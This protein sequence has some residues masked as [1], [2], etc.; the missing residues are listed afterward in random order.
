MES[1]TAVPFWTK[2]GVPLRRKTGDVDVVCHCCCGVSRVPGFF[3]WY[4]A[5]RSELTD[6]EHTRVHP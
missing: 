6:E 2:L 5:R 1:F 4:E 3:A